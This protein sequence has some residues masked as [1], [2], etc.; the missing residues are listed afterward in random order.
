MENN[1]VNPYLEQL[2]EMLEHEETTLFVN[3][4]HLMDFSEALASLLQQDFYRSVCCRLKGSVLCTLRCTL[5]CLILLPRLV[6][7]LNTYSF[8]PF[9]RES[10][11]NF[12][13]K[14]VD[15]NLVAVEQNPNMEY[16][17]AFHS[18]PTVQR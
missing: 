9:I 13:Q 8:D 7:A 10:L 15:N 6:P 17:V 14:A 16:I 12:V 18:M 4:E 5:F 2:K 1:T 11:R 3:F